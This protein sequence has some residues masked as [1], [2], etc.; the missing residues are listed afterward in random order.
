MDVA[1]AQVVA[2]ELRLLEPGVRSEGEGVLGMLHPDFTEFGSSGRVWDRESVMIGISEDTATIMASD[3]AAHQLADDVVLVTYTT[4]R[5]DQRARRSS[6]WV[7][8]DDKWLLRF[9]QGTPSN[10]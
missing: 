10:G 7:R 8:Q 9:H 2:N 3:V 6:L 1:L 5:G 4:Q